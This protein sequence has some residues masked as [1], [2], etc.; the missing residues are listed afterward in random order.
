MERPL[1]RA[2]RSFAPGATPASAAS[3]K[4]T[5]A[6][7]SAANPWNEGTASEVSPLHQRSHR[8]GARAQRLELGG[9]RRAELGDARAAEVVGDERP[10]PCPLPT[11]AP[12]PSSSPSPPRR[13]STWSSSPPSR[14]RALA[15][16]AAPPPA[17]RSAARRYRT[18][19]PRARARARARSPSHGASARRSQTHLGSRVRLAQPR[20]R[21]SLEQSGTHRWKTPIGA[22]PRGHAGSRSPSRQA[23]IA[24]GSPAVRGEARRVVEE[25]ELGAGMGGAGLLDDRADGLARSRGRRHLRRVRLLERARNSMA[26]P[27]LQKT[28]RRRARSGH[29]KSTTVLS[30]RTRGTW[31]TSAGGPARDAS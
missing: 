20:F 9:L 15:P 4:L 12:P 31:T 6:S 26:I 29:L 16:R 28:S 17:R 10:G 7:A 3:V 25:R 5:M 21:I 24:F 27:V 18:R 30:S 22:V 1:S 13:L 11:G 14:A 19:S 23:T 8:A 2:A